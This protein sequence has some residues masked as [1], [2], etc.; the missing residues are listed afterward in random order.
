MKT[1][2]GKEAI[3]RIG[4]PL[5]FLIAG[6]AWGL[7]AAPS[8]A[9]LLE[10]HC[11][12][13]DQGS[14]E[15]VIGPNGTTI[16]IDGGVW[17]MGPRVVS[18]IREALPQEFPRIDYL[19]ATHDD[20]D[21]YG[22]LQYLLLYG[23]IE[24]DVIYHCGNNS[25]F[26]Y[27]SQIPLGLDI[28][29]G[30]G[31]R[32]ICVGRE[33]RFIDN[34]QG[35]T[36]GN[37]DSV[38]FLIQYGNFDYLTAGDL[39]S[40]EYYLAPA[41]LNYPPLD[42]LL[43]TQYGVDVLH[44]NHHGSNGSSCASYINQLKPEVALINGGTNYGHPRRN[45]VDRL[46]GRTHYTNTYSCDPDSYGQPTYV[47][48]PG[49]DVFRTTA[50]YSYDCKRAP[51]SDCP[52]LGNIR[53]TYDGCSTWYYV[54]REAYEVD[55]PS[56]CATPT[57][58]P[59][60]YKTPTPSPT[61]SATP[62]VTPTPY[63]YKTPTRSPTPTPSRSPTPTPSPTART[64]QA[65]AGDYD[66]DGSADLA[67]FRPGSGLWLVKG[68]TRAYFGAEGDSPVP[69]DYDGDGTW[70][71][72]V[73]RSA[74]GKWMVRGGPSWYHGKYYDLPVAADYRGDHKAR[75]AVFRP[76]Q[77]LWLL[78][79]LTRV[80]WGA[81]GD[82][83]VPADYGGDGSSEIAVFRPGSGK[84]LLPNQPVIY[85]GG[86]DDIPVPFDYQGKGKAEIAVFRASS[87]KWLVRNLGAFFY[88]GSEDTVTPA[89]FDGNGSA[90][91]AV[92]RRGQG[93]WLVR[94]LLTAYFGVATDQP[95]TSP[96]S[97]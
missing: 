29:L 42:P 33:S 84:W 9:G 60:G 85:F 14:S 6:L 4:R 91:I 93:K 64:V 87:G 77:G 54:N 61:S 83:P 92:F 89:D 46:K 57:P 78:Q 75:P 25:G 70:D 32:A 28:D 59:Y 34:S 21:H 81:Y 68:L 71:I 53:V 31:A 69:E 80:Y 8:G 95:V 47:T 30:D 16:L 67:V 86:A 48:V 19:V 50:P 55:E 10:I 11:I 82:V 18:C 97:R 62:S 36:G 22:G 76:L 51:E 88:G 23:D 49:A 96:L 35:W 5:I 15:L 79:G 13:V 37:N 39:E 74:L 40:N 20:S 72:A 52:S 1:R 38:C 7:P 65:V 27:G 17:D 12:D 26:G 58:T 66:G 24:V 45:A 73:F 90:D 63:G 3:S 41:L 2:A 94:N 56:S 44:V 43:K